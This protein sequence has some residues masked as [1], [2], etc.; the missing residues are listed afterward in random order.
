MARYYIYTDGGA[1]GN[2]GPAATGVV[3]LDAQKKKIKTASSYLGEA[4]N[5]VAEYAALIRALELVV[6]LAE[7]PLENIEIHAYLDSELIVKQLKGNYK[8]KN[9]GLKPLFEQVNK[10]SLPFRKITYTH[11]P[12]EENAEADMLV[13]E[14]LDKHV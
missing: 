1:R 5:N 11:I 6:E 7:L 14:E 3:I 2:P 12:R 9:K 13:N 8:V 4:T 10:L